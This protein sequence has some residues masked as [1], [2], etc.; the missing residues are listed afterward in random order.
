MYLS[1][2]MHLMVLLYKENR[3]R[4]SKKLSQNTKVSVT[5]CRQLCPLWLW[6]HGVHASQ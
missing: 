2:D 4:I 3:V 6:G 5:L 1:I